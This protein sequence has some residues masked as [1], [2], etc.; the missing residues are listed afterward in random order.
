MVIVLTR[1]YHMFDITRGLCVDS[2]S[3]RCRHDVPPPIWPCLQHASNARLN[4]CR[5]GFLCLISSSAPFS[6]HT[7]QMPQALAVSPTRAEPSE[8]TVSPFRGPVPGRNLTDK[9]R[10]MEDYYFACGASGD[11]WM[12]LLDD[13]NSECVKKV[14]FI[15]FYHLLIFLEF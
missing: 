3:P 14:Y 6:L 11:V 7:S 2:P 13:H 10:P 4:P 15:L 9:V 1:E 12:G 8:Q 5:H